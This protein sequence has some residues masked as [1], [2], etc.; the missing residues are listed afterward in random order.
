MGLNVNDD[1]VCSLRD[2]LDNDDR[3]YVFTNG[4]KYGI[5]MERFNICNIKVFIYVVNDYVMV[6]KDPMSFLMGLN[7]V[8]LCKVHISDPQM[9]KI[10][11]AYVDHLLQ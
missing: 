9:L 11:K 1:I 7:H 10:I 3:I 5:C 6:I 4:N 8:V 2:F